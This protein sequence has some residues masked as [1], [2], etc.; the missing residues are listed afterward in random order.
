MAE[1]P[2]C[3]RGVHDFG[4][5]VPRSFIAIM[6][7]DIDDVAAAKKRHPIEETRAKIRHLCSIPAPACSAGTFF[8]ALTQN[9]LVYCGE[10]KRMRELA[11]GPKT[12]FPRIAYSM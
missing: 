2:G 9:S 8:L 6:Q 5:R 4:N 7:A 11:Q 3:R 12:A 10:H 1:D